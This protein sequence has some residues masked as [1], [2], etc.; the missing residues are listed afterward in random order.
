MWAPAA[1]FQRV[2]PADF[3]NRQRS[4]RS[5]GRALNI[6]MCFYMGQLRIIIC[7][8]I[9]VVSLRLAWQPSILHNIPSASRAPPHTWFIDHLYHSYP[10]SAPAPTPAAAA[11]LPLLPLTF[12]T[13]NLWFKDNEVE[14]RINAVLDIIERDM[15]TFVALQVGRA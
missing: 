2:A 8:R 7:A 11:Y 5:C 15:P 3:Q 1:S 12:L 13:Y 10:A 4:F 9:A 6:S 14:V